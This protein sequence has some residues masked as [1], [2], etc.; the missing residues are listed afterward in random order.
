MRGSSD[1]ATSTSMSGSDEGKGTSFICFA[2]YGED[3][4]S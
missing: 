2:A 4:L 3:D 1:I